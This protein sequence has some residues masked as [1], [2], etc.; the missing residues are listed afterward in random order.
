[1]KLFGRRMKARQKMYWEVRPGMIGPTEDIQTEVKKLNKEIRQN[2][3][4]DCMEAQ[5]QPLPCGMAQMLIWLWHK[6][7]Q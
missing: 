2:R 3:M 7:C 6:D 1:M 5:V 4:Q